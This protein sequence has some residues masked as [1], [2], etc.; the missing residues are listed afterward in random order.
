MRFYRNPHRLRERN[1]LQ[2]RQYATLSFTANFDGR[3][4]YC[5]SVVGGGGGGG[6][7]FPVADSEL[8]PPRST[9]GQAGF[10]GAKVSVGVYLTPTARL[11]SGGGGDRANFGIYYLSGAA[12]YAA[13]DGYA[14]MST[15]IRIANPGASYVAAGGAPGKGAWQDFWPSIVNNESAW[16][17]NPVSRVLGQGGRGRNPAVAQDFG[18]SGNVGG[19]EIRYGA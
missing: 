18:S 2:F 16:N 7:G 5:I 17:A 13:Y 8:S 4:V 10:P 14:G 9:R 3:N 19:I 12:R 1:F 15:T 11:E 6:G